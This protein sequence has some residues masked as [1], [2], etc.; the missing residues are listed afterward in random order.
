MTQP[1]VLS[2]PY[3]NGCR[4]I[5]PWVELGWNWERHST[6]LRQA[7][8]LNP[9]MDSGAP[10]IVEILKTPQEFMDICQILSGFELL[11]LPSPEG[12]SLRRLG[13]PC[14]LQAGPALPVS[15]KDLHRSGGNER[16]ELDPLAQTL[17]YSCRSSSLPIQQ[18][19]QEWVVNK[20]VQ[21][22]VYTCSCPLSRGY[23][24]LSLHCFLLS[25]KADSQY[26]HRAPKPIIQWPKQLCEMRLLA[27]LRFLHRKALMQL[28]YS[29]G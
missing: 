28:T 11:C 29:A 14:C 25:P 2:V 13:P 9:I 5:F 24:N 20:R 22:Q 3:E 4:W 6:S 23:S 1:V 16:A 10:C 12:W 15:E 21:G 18:S 8:A 17:F 7:D 19:V 26:Q 27:I